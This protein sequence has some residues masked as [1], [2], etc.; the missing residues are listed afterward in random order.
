MPASTVAAFDA[1]GIE[2]DERTEAA[3]LFDPAK[4]NVIFASAVDGWA[5]TVRFSA[6][7]SSN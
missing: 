2:V 7:A 1:S 4:G 3:L 5:F 6:A